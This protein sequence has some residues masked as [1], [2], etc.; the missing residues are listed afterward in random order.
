MYDFKKILESARTIAVIGC[1]AD[2]SRTSFAISRYL[3]EVGYQI[4]PVNPNHREVHGLTCYPDVGRI[5][6]DL[7]IDIVNIFR[8]PAFTADMVRDVL[9]RI[10]RTGEKPVI[11]TQIGVSSSVAE[12]LTDESGLVYVK[13]RCIMVEHSHLGGA[14][15][16]QPA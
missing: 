9:K 4:I 7:R 6:D 5:A 3:I 12:K 10:E 15:Y 8:R 16:A 2:P 11:W 13:N 14:R 1:S